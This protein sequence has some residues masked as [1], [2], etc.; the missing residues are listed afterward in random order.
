MSTPK[1]NTPKIN[2]LEHTGTKC[3]RE[4]DN[5]GYDLCDDCAHF[6]ESRRYAGDISR[7]RPP[8]RKAAVEA[9]RVVIGDVDT[10]KKKDDEDVEEKEEEEDSDSGSD[11]DTDDEDDDDDDDDDAILGMMNSTE[12]DLNSPRG[13]GHRRRKKVDY[14]ALAGELGLDGDV[15]SDEDREFTSGSRL[16]S[17]ELNINLRKLVQEKE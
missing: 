17:H 5:E 12:L 1:I 15:S 3:E 16:Q 6:R 10:E 8:K 7:K 4:D 13:F 9:L 2:I 14:V 11:F